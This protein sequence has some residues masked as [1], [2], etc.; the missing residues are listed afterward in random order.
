MCLRDRLYVSKEAC[1]IVFEGP[2]ATSVYMQ[3]LGC[4]FYRFFKKKCCCA[5]SQHHAQIVHLFVDRTLVKSINLNK[6]KESN[7]KCV[8]IK[9][10]SDFGDKEKMIQRQ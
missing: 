8:F 9:G 3:Q 7:M 5:A 10:V 2:L 6:F 4:K 1:R